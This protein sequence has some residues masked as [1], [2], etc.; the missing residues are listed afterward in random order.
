MNV[1]EPLSDPHQFPPAKA[2]DDTVDALCELR[3]RHGID[4]AVSVGRAVLEGVYGGDIERLRDRNNDCPTLRSLAAHPRIPFNLTAL[5]QAIGI[6]CLVERLPELP[7]TELTATHLRLV[8]PYGDDVQDRLLRQALAEEWTTKQLEQAARAIKPTRGKG[9]RPRLPA[10]VKTLNQLDRLAGEGTAWAD[11]DALAGLPAER[12]AVLA[13]KVARLRRYLRGVELRLGEAVEGEV[14]EP[15]EADVAE[16]VEG[17][18]AE[19]IEGDVA[20]P[21]KGECAELVEDDVAGPAE[22]DAAGP[23]EGDA[24]GPVEG[25]AAE[26]FEGDVTEPIDSTDNPTRR[27]RTE[28]PAAEH[29]TDEATPV[30]SPSTEPPL[31]DEP[32]P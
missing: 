4:L 32:R 1:F 7:Q 17:D 3:R 2:V 29:R 19:P 6:Y 16:P 13:R 22:G 28:P 5:H 15:V 18:V 27:E 20:E 25:D 8:L 9:G 14:A 24:A 12:R 21:V 26:P 31:L 30:A 11:L 10:A 23:V